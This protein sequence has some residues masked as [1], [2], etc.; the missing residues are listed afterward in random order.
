[1]LDERLTLGEA[2]SLAMAASDCRGQGA[3]DPVRTFSLKIKARM[4]AES[5]AKKISRMNRKN[6]NEKGVGS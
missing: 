6:C 3:W 1:M 2:G 5:S 4:A